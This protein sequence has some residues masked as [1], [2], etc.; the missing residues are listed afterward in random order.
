MHPNG[1]STDAVS[2]KL[3]SATA[4]PLID[5]SF[6]TVSNYSLYPKSAK[7]NAKAKDTYSFTSTLVTVSILLI[8]DIFLMI[9]SRSSVLC[10]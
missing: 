4:L 10:T 3:L 8:L 7:A 5:K 9:M 1:P 6:I 2:N